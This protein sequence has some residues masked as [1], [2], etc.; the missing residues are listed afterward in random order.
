VNFK[1]FGIRR[2]K[3][4]LHAAETDLAVRKISSRTW[5]AAQASRKIAHL[6]MMYRFAFTDAS[7]VRRKEVIW[8]FAECQA[9]RANSVHSP[10]GKSDKRI[11]Q[12]LSDFF[13]ARTRKKRI[14][15]INSPFL[16][17]L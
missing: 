6:G 8:T 14:K 3:W 4:E 17:R 16:Q 12:R 7:D 2:I 11:L 5:I 13:L 9:F 1:N 10:S 15:S